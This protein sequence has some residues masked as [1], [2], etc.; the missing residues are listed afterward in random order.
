MESTSQQTCDLAS[1]SAADTEIVPIPKEDVDRVAGIAAPILEMGIAALRGTATVMGL[2]H[3]CIQD[4]KQLWLEFDPRSTTVAV[5]IVTE[6]VRFETA[7]MARIVLVCG[8]GLFRAPV[9]RYLGT[10]EEW[11]RFQGCDRIVIEGRDGWK[12]YLPE[13]YTAIARVWERKL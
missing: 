9:E 11:A 7:F 3:D 13:T 12:R 1:S 4:R 2:L 8:V 10:I 6:L 5:A